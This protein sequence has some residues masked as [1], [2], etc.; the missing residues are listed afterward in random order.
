MCVCIGVVD[1]SN[2]LGCDDS[3]N[4]DDDDDGG[5]GGGGGGGGWCRGNCLR[6]EE[7]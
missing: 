3:G 2:I 5:G 4:D 6:C 1:P 7:L